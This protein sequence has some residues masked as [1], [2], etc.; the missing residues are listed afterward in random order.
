MKTPKITALGASTAAAV[1][2]GAVAFSM[3]FTALTELAAENGTNGYQAWGFPV[4]VDGLMIGATAATVGLTNKASRAYA[5]FALA[6]GSALSLAGNV[7]H[8]VQGGQGPIGI[9]IAA[10]IPIVLFVVTHLTV[11]LAREK[12][13]AA[14]VGSKPA[15]AAKVTLSESIAVET[16]ASVETVEDPIAHEKLVAVG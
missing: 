7:A 8:A 3:S 6:L 10:I 5:Y 16:P 14:S 12:F 4:I 13:S 15:D 2:I 11:L 9:A 1:G